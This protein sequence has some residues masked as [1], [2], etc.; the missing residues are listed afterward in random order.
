MQHAAAYQPQF[1]LCIPVFA[2]PGRGFFRTPG[3]AS[4]DPA[5]AVQ[6]AVDAESFGYDS[7]WVAD[8]LIHGVDGGILEGW[9]T[10]CVIAGRTSRIKLGTIHLAQPFRE[11]AMAAKM[12]ASL[13]ALSGGRLIFFYDCGWNA[14]EVQAYGLAWPDEAERIDR[15]DEGLDLIKHLWSDAA[16]G[17]FQ[18]RYYQT[19]DAVCLPGPVQRPRPPIWLGEARH[20]A[21]LDVICRHAD[22]WNSVPASVARLGEK[23]AGVRASCQRIGRDVSELEISLEIQILV[24]PTE[25]EAR[26]ELLRIADL[27]LSPRRPPR[28]DLVTAV[29]DN[30]ATPLSSLIDDWLVGDPAAVAARIREYQS[31]GVSHFMLWFLDLPSR[32]GLRLFAEQVIP[33]VNAGAGKGGSA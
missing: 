13:D 9:T 2:N 12:A 6:S 5:D 19:H 32:E 33:L 29:R 30:P 21:W 22:G 17:D 16:P 26:R 8:H 7:I 23:L 4:L 14:Q 27:P 15:M 18:G 10:L 1:G 25:A 28:D 3:L 24:R 11:P 20:D 31:L